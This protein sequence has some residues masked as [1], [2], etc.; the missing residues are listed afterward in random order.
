MPPRCYAERFGAEK[1]FAPLQTPFPAVHFS[2][3]REKAGAFLPRPAALLLKN[4]VKIRH[5]LACVF[6]NPMG[7]RRQAA[8]GDRLK[9]G[10]GLLDIFADA[11]QVI[12][13]QN[14]LSLPR[15]D[16]VV[17]QLSVSL[18]GTVGDQPHRAVN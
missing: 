11:H 3:G 1:Q 12:F 18:V 13:Y 16:K 4:S 17:E 14:F 7:V 8:L 15:E 2:L 10:V 9:V 5:N 6:S